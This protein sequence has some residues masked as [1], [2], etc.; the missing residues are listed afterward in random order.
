MTPAERKR[1]S[2]QARMKAMDRL[3][4][5]PSTHRAILAGIAADPLAPPVARVA[6]CRT[7]LRVEAPQFHCR[8]ARTHAGDFEEIELSGR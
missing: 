7:L 2:R 8:A 3:M 6:A 4:P 5:I 1:K